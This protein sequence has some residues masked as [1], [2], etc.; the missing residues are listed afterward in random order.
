MN[1][2]EIKTKAL[3][4]SGIIFETNILK[5]QVLQAYYKNLQLKFEDL[6]SKFR[7]KEYLLSTFKEI[8]EENWELIK[9]TGISYTALPNNRVTQLMIGISLY[10]SHHEP[11]TH[12]LVVL[13]PDVCF[14]SCSD[15]FPDLNTGA[16]K[17]I[18]KITNLLKTHILS[19]NGNYLIPVKLAT[20]I[21]INEELEQVPNPYFNYKDHAEDE[22]VLSS[23]ETS[24][25]FRHSH[26]LKT[27]LTHKKTYCDIAQNETHLLG[28]FQKL[29]ER[30]RIASRYG[31]GSELHAGNEA[32]Q[33]VID[34]IAIY[35]HYFGKKLYLCDQKPDDL[36]TLKNSFLWVENKKLFYIN[37][38]STEQIKL[39]DN[40]LFRQ[41]LDRFK[42]IR[43]HDS[44]VLE[45]SVF[46]MHQLI[47]SNS[48]HQTV[49][50]IPSPLHKHI[51]KIIEFVTDPQSNRDATQSMQT[52]VHDLRQ[53]LSTYILQYQ[54][55]L[56]QF[57]SSMDE[58]INLQPM[59]QAFN[60]AR[61]HIGSLLENES[62][63]HGADDLQNYGDL[64][65]SLEVNFE[66]TDISDLRFIKDYDQQTVQGVFSFEQIRA[67][68]VSVF[69]N[70]DELL[71]YLMDLS[72]PLVELFVDETQ[73]ELCEL[74]VTDL[75]KLGQ[76]L[77]VLDAERCAVILKALREIRIP[78]ISDFIELQT[79]LDVQPFHSACASLK[80]HFIA[81]LSPENF[82]E[83]MQ[84]LQTVEKQTIFKECL[85]SKVVELIEH[86]SE[87][88]ALQ[89]V[90]SADE[91]HVISS[92]IK[93]KMILGL[94]NAKDFC[95]CI[96]ILNEDEVIA[97][98]QQ[99]QSKLVSW[100][101]NIEALKH[102]FIHTPSSLFSNLHA[103][104]EEKLKKIII[105]NH[106]FFDLFQSL[107]QT[108]Q[109]MFLQLNKEYLFELICKNPDSHIW[110][111]VPGVGNYYW[112]LKPIFIHLMASSNKI[113]AYEFMHALVLG[114]E[115]IIKE[116]YEKL[117]QKPS[118]SRVN[119]FKQLTQI[120]SIVAEL[121][122]LPQELT[123]KIFKALEISKPYTSDPNALKQKFKDYITDKLD[124]KPCIKKMKVSPFSR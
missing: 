106:D 57:T 20:V 114:D 29:C 48:D 4:L 100:A 52:C 3:S 92:Q 90:L 15:D 58:S 69:Q 13:M 116:K 60:D 41:T 124:C 88:F 25:L 54:D 113:K 43:G 6:F 104:F 9:Y 70:L 56:I 95:L 1:L 62:Y 28:Q 8:L 47:E 77:T 31:N 73:I 37:S 84:K 21:E 35:N 22:A 75:Q 122:K 120:D 93:P 80:E 71:E 111:H 5:E 51:L 32:Y 110:K 87:L 38:D 66:I 36:S 19:F 119:F 121:V 64:I 115:S 107:S 40:S 109:D 63:H 65:E 55:I 102:I 45:L 11:D 26:L 17:R 33:G 50:E 49:P 53:K 78:E 39:E 18:D 101:I 79:H 34:F 85:L 112:S 108:K 67:Q 7:D 117:I 24:R 83:S 68:A 89:P 118:H 103:Q 99:Y 86:I 2:P 42:S 72:V 91:F 97:L 10:V 76:F 14:E 30:L 123:K 46:E 74:H 59:I 96:S 44:Q 16:Y 94:D 98:Y 81:N 105:N 12:P 61:Q 23:E 27:L 82:I